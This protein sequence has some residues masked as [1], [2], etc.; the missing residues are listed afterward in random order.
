MGI[1]LNY[2]SEVALGKDFSG[3]SGLPLPIIIL[4]IL[5]IH[6]SQPPRYVTILANYDVTCSVFT[7][8][9]V[10]PKSDQNFL[11]I[12]IASSTLTKTGSAECISVSLTS[13]TTCTTSY[14]YFCTYS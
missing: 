2:P 12:S 11:N 7:S 10:L 8:N 6:L 5:H 9:F 1:M 3:Y 13:L 4:P 14:I